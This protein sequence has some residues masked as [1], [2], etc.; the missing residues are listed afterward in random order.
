[1]DNLI[2]IKKCIS[3]LRNFSA[4]CYNFIIKFVCT[5]YSEIYIFFL[6][7]KHFPTIPRNHINNYIGANKTEVDKYLLYEHV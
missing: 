4:N 7:F 5:L 1:M 3:V 2:L 6:N